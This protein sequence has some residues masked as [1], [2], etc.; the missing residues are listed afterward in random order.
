MPGNDLEYLE[1]LF[2]HIEFCSS[3]QL[4]VIISEYFCLEVEQED[5]LGI[6]ASLFCECFRR[7]IFARQMTHR[8]GNVR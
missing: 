2:G 5:E 8:N 6:E 3:E 7:K 4:L 1:A